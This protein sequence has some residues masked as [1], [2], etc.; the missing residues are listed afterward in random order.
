MRK[1]LL[2]IFF[3]L[4]VLTGCITNDIPYP[5]VVPH[6]TSFEVAGAQSVDVDQDNQIVTVN[7]AETTDM[8]SVEIRSVEFDEH[9]ASVD[10]AITGFHDFTSPFKFIV[11]TYDDYVWTVKGVRNVERYFTINGQIGTSVIDAVNCRAIA[12]V[13]M[14]ADLT[15]LEVTSLKLGPAG[16]TEYSIEPSQMKDFSEGISVEVTAFGLTEVWTL[17][18]EQTDVSVEI[19]KVNPWTTE[20]YITSMGVSGMDNGFFYREKGASEWTEASQSDIT[21]DGGTFV[22]HIKSLKAETDYEVYAYCGTDKTAVSEFTTDKAEKIP[23]GSF[24]YASKVDG[25][26][27]YK[28]YDPNCGVADGSYMFWGSGNGEGNEG[29]SGS[30]SMGIIITYIDT[31]EKVDGK[32]SVRAQTSQMA[33]ILAA[34]NL[35]AGQFDGLVGTSGGRVNFGRPWTTRPRAVKLWCK[36]STGTMDIIKGSP[37][38]VTLVKGETYDRAELKFALGYW[39]YKKYG[40]SKNSPVH[41]NTTDP[42]TFIDFNTDPCTIANGGL[43][44]HHDGYILNGETKVSEQ[45]NTWVEYTIPLNYRDID[46]LPTHIVVSCAASQF[47]DYFSGCSSS[48]LWLDKVELVY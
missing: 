43:I 5:V 3:G 2:Y 34:G 41:V 18:V 45:T 23:N 15:A 6:L 44:I 48:K 19:K 36:Y 29:V 4:I 9:E 17:F 26:D 1:A 20:A 12:T 42:S 35:F 13:G 39:D 31:N 7:F 37:A 22:A 8:R 14:N 32:Q 27:Y 24:E 10:K 46:T 25:K 16:L 28:F 38:G 21:A 33:G 47:G 40:G 11:K 30:A